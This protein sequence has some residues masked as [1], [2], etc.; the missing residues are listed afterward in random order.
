MDKFNALSD[1]EK[2]T[3]EGKRYL[4][5][6]DFFDN[7]IAQGHRSLF[8]F[9]KNLDVPIYATY[10][11]DTIATGQ[12][13]KG[14]MNRMTDL[15]REPRRFL[16]DFDRRRKEHLLKSGDMTYESNIKKFGLD[17]IINNTKSTNFRVFEIL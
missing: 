11:I 7:L 9:Y 3:R 4:V 2:S 1:S 17:K 14:F 10:R 12:Y 5:L 15:P 13:E 16:S 8:S 6:V